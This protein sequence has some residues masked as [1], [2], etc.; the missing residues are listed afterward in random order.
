MARKGRGI[1][2]KLIIVEIIVGFSVA[3]GLG[4]LIIINNRDSMEAII[5]GILWMFCLTV[6]IAFRIRSRIRKL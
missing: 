1:V 2:S 6:V 5:G 3:Y 4:I